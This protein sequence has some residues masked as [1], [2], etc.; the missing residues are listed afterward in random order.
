MAQKR[1]LDNWSFQDNIKYLSTQNEW[2]GRGTENHIIKFK[3][4]ED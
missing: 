4:G 1:T 2:D 3:W